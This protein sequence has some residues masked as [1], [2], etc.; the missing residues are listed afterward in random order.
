MFCQCSL[1]LARQRSRLDIG[2]VSLAHAVLLGLLHRQSV[3]G[4]LFRRPLRHA[5]DDSA[6][7]ILAMAVRLRSLLHMDVHRFHLLDGLVSHTRING[8][9]QI[10]RTDR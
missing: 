1:S 3:P 7:D 6:L 5:A 8:L 2:E 10:L 9:G 4:G